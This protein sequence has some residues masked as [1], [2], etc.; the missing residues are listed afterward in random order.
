MQLREAALR[1]ES[2]GEHFGPE[3]RAAHA[4]HDGVGEFLAL[5]ASREILVVGD[6]GVSSTGEPSQPL[7]LVVAGPDRLVL[8]PQPADLCRGAPFLAVLLDRLL[9]ACA[10]RKLLR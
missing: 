7:V 6:I 3:A 8:A 2:L 4:E 5:H 10:E 9:D 1:R